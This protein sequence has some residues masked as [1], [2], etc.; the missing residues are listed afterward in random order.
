MT[1]LIFFKEKGFS[2]KVDPTKLE[3]GTVNF[4]YIIGSVEDETIFKVDV[5]LRFFF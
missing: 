4:G 1:H 2:V 3:A 5:L